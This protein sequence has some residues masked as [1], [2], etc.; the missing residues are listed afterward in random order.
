MKTYLRDKIREEDTKE[1]K[2]RLTVKIKKSVDDPLIFTKSES[3]ESKATRLLGGTVGYVEAYHWVSTTY[4]TEISDEDKTYI[5]DQLKRKIQRHLE[6]RP[7]IPA[8]VQEIVPDNQDNDNHQIINE[9]RPDM[10]DRPVSPHLE[11]QPIPPVQV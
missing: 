2:K 8:Q 7:V 10:E 3:N 6:V 5:T 9:Q 11:V 4:T 1:K